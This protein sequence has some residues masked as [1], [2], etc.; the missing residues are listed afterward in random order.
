[1]SASVHSQLRCRPV[2][3]FAAPLILL[4]A[5]L[6]GN[7]IGVLAASLFPR[8][9]DSNT[10]NHKACKCLASSLGHTC[11]RCLNV[12]ASAVSAKVI[13]TSENVQQCNV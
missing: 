12:P 7:N 3:D 6:G 5:Q 9:H 2:T 11:S 4:P 13:S 1:M 8:A 10:A